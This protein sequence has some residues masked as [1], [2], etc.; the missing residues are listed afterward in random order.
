MDRALSAFVLAGNMMLFDKNG[1]I[2]KYNSPEEILRDFYELRM[3]YY[4]RR[5]QHLIQ[6]RCR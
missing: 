4:V 5:R 6:A 1:I 3:E 2:K